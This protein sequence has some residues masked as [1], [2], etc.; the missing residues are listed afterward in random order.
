[1]TQVQIYRYIKLEF[2]ACTVQYLKRSTELD[3]LQSKR[4]VYVIYSIDFEMYVWGILDIRALS[5][6]T[7]SVKGIYTERT[8]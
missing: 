2:T 1:M 4:K 3:L 6:A 8:F 5:T 7:E